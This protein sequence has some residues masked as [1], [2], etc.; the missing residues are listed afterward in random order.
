MRDKVVLITGV[1]GMGGATARRLVAAGARVVLV[2]RDAEAAAALAAE[3]GANALGVVADVTDQA[4][5]RGAADR[6]CEAFGGIDA[7]L[8]SAGI[9]G[10]MR[11]VDTLAPATFDEVIEVDL[12]GVWR[13]L[14]ATLPAL[15]RNRGYFLAMSSAYALLPSPLMAPY[16]AAKAGVEALCRAARIELTGTGVAVGVAYAGLVTTPLLEAFVAGNRAAVDARSTVTADRLGRFLL[17]GPAT[18]S[19]DQAAKAL[20]RGIRRRSGR[21]YTHRYLRV[22]QATRGIAMPIDAL[23]GRLAPVRAVIDAARLAEPHR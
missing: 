23:L 5:V 19:P 15:Q 4:A 20:V 14:H 13:T 21:V 10:A 2:D 12:L 7:V 16:G 17:A 22:A 18:I 11:P 1:R 6:A 9:A 3:L 8:A